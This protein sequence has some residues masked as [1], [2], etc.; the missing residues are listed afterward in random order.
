MDDDFLLE[1]SKDASLK[2]KEIYHKIRDD[3]DDNK[4]VDDDS[5]L[6]S[7]MAL[8]LTWRWIIPRETIQV[9]WGQERFAW[10]FNYDLPVWYFLFKF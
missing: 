7:L 6:K 4:M 8:V 5:L 9:I 2:N 3:V 10:P 1:M